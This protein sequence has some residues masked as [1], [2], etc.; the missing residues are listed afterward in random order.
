M[1]RIGVGKTNWP[2][3]DY[4]AL[5]HTGLRNEASRSQE[6]DEI[7]GR[8]AHGK[9]HRLDLRDNFAALKNLEIAF[10]RSQ[11]GGEGLEEPFYKAAR[12]YPVGNRKTRLKQIPFPDRSELSMAHLPHIALTIN[13]NLRY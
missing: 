2:W 6:V 12:S 8:S 10:E 1:K 5:G 3:A 7:E 11:F 4:P 13:T 9:P